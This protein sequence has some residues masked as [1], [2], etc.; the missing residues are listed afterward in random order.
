MMSESLAR[1]QQA[2]LERARAIEA[3]LRALVTEH[4]PPGDDPNLLA[5]DERW[6]PTVRVLVG[7]W[8][9]LQRAFWEAETR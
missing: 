1:V 2:R 4:L 6:A 5:L 9:A 8:R 3:Q 7:E